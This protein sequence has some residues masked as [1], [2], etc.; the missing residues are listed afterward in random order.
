MRKIIFMLLMMI[1]ISSFGKFTYTISDNGKNFIKKHETCQLVAYWDVNGYSIGWGHH[2][3][4]VYK[5]MKI[6]QIQANKYFDEDIKEV[7]MAANRIINSLP[8]KY[9]FS[10]N[11]FDSLCSLVYN[12]GE[13]GVKSTNFYKRLKSC[14]VKNG[15]MNMNDFNFTVAAVKTSKISV[16]GHK[17]RR[18]NEYK[19]MIS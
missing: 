10:Q 19:L 16:P 8:Y 2:S 12:C 13:G 17:E 9:K 3:K 4:D 1:S 14:R 7:E 11:F 5:G 15:K 6:S 18:L